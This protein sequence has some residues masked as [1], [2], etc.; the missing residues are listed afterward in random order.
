MVLYFKFKEYL[1]VKLIFCLILF[2]SVLDRVF[3][4]FFRDFFFML[5]IVK[6]F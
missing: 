6:R 5:F 3:L 2:F 1:R 4:R